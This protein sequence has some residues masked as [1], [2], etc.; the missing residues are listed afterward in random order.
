MPDIKVI[1]HTK[2]IAS[3]APSVTDSGSQFFPLPLKTSNPNYSTIKK[4]KQ[5]EEQD[6]DYSSFGFGRGDV[7]GRS[8]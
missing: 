3:I 1:W 7:D 6:S 4:Q 8:D 5:D 2:A